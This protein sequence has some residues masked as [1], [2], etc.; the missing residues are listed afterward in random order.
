[1]N[2][3]ASECGGGGGELVLNLGAIM[4]AESA[5]KQIAHSAQQMDFSSGACGP[6]PVT[7]DLARFNANHKLPGNGP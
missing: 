3:R 2:S 7:Y 4:H 1:M 5:N 6:F